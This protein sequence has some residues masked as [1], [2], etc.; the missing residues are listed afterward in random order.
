[1]KYSAMA[2]AL[3]QLPGCT[4]LGFKKL[5]ES[6]RRPRPIAPGAKIRIAQIG[7]GGVGGGDV[8]ACSEEDVVALCDVDWSLT[9]V[10]EVSDKFPQA[11]HFTDF[12]EMLLE[13]DDQIDAVVISTP[14]HMHFLPAF[15]A[16][17]MGKHVYVQKP[18]TQT[19]EEARLL[20]E[21]ARQHGVCTQMGNQGHSNEGTRLV[22]EWVQG[23]VIGQVREVHVWTNRPVWPQGMTE[24]AAAEPLPK[25][26]NW[27]AWLGRAP[28][29]PFSNAYHPFKWRGWRDFG[30]GALG[31][32]GCHL[33]DASF[34]ALDLATPTLIT[35]ESSG[36]TA[37]A[38]PEW[39]RIT[40][41]FPARG[42]L[43]PVTVKWSDGGKLP[44]RPAELET[45]RELN[46]GGQILIGDKGVIYDANDYCNSPRLIPESKMAAMKGKLPPKTLPRIPKGNHHGNWLEAIRL[47]KPA[48][49]VS[50]FEYSVP[51]TE[52]VVL[53]NLALFGNGRVEWDAKNRQV[54][55][56]PTLNQYLQPAY[57][58]G[59]N[60][61]DLHV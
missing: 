1:M 47:N 44:E 41:E 60:P 56:D 53:G 6:P 20:L 52:M 19:V 48:H 25:D 49:A 36:I 2:A 5:M 38:Y 12:R 8:K 7:L 57:R 32:M 40:Y 22:R 51:L 18:L 13:M 33:L 11:R 10:Q 28:E 61:K 39:S 59:W 16:I 37:E 3:L 9:K 26:L 4:R 55:N 24:R 21:L 14:D 27:N 23:G 50:N 35:A 42:A 58:S 43:P 31:D 17:A 15:M 46:K 30:A 54:A 29:R 34:W 45:D